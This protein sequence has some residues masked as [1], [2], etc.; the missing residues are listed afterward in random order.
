M[1]SVTFNDTSDQVICGG[2]DNLVKI[3]DRRTKKVK[4]SS[5]KIITDKQIIYY[6]GLL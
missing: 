5:Q 6:T 1:T 4:R 3:Y 2:I